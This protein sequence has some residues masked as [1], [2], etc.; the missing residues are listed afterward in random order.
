MRAGRI[1]DVGRH[2]PVARRADDQVD[3][4]RP[5]RMPAGAGRRSR[6]PARRRESCTEQAGR[7]RRRGRPP[8]VRKRPRRCASGASGS[9]RRVSRS[10]PFCQTSRNSAPAIGRPLR[11]STRPWTPPRSPAGCS[12]SAAP[13][14]PSRRARHV[15]GAEHGRL[16]GL[17]GAGFARASTSIE[18]PSASDQRTNSWRRSSVIRPVS[19]SSSNPSSLLLRQTDLDRE[20]MEVVDEAL[21]ERT[22][23]LVAQPSKTRNHGR[24]DV[25]RCCPPVAR[26]EPRLNE[27]TQASLVDGHATGCAESLHV[28]PREEA[29]ENCVARG[30]HGGRLGAA[31]RLRPAPSSAPREHK[32][33]ARGLRPSVP[34]CSSIRT[35]SATS[36]ARRSARG[37][38]T[39]TSA[40]RSSRAAPTRSSGTS[41]PPRATTEL[42]CP[43]LPE[44]SW[45]AWVSPMRGAMGN[46]R[47]PPGPRRADP[48]QAV[49]AG[50]GRRAAGHRRRT[51]RRC[52][53]CRRRASTSPTRSR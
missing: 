32:A 14:S 38:G 17:A 3:V 51:R 7:R 19:V 53:R 43:W 34:C 40:S 48:R 16:G 52:S 11:S 46:S 37:S 21:R 12:T 6:R 33:G 26:C 4:R 2:R 1:E 39:R 24:R 23:P 44:S 22:Q 35:T 45:R 41:A 13:Y 29:Y 28:E 47:H 25:L 50:P 10:S 31:G 49:R 20:G 8:R 9:G 42:Y 5:P 36:R 30:D 18:R 27:T 15:E